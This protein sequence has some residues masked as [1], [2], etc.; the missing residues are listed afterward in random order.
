MI[1]VERVWSCFKRTAEI[2]LVSRQ[3]TA[4]PL[5]VPP[6]SSPVVTSLTALS[7]WCHHRYCIKTQDLIVVWLRSPLRH[8]SL[9]LILYLSSLQCY[10]VR[11]LQYYRVVLF[12]SFLFKRGGSYIKRD[13]FYV[14]TGIIRFSLV[15]EHCKKSKPSNYKFV[16]WI[17]DWGSSF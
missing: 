4:T 8:R 5:H 16:R 14:C 12:F 10:H 11:S 3:V 13:E 9:T 6:V 2:T 17:K 1:V 15:V 7:L